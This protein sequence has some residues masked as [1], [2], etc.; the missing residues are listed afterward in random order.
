M[1]LLPEA[2][3]IDDYQM[4]DGSRSLLFRMTVSAPDRTLTSEEVAAERQRLIDALR[5]AGYELRA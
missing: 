2:E 3:F 4:S 1:K 5:G